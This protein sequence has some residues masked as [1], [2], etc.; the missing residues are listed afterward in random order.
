MKSSFVIIF[1]LSNILV[2]Y[3]IVDIN[4]VCTVIQAQLN[5]RKFSYLQIVCTQSYL[6]LNSILE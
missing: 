4:Q 5:V 1:A 2:T 3:I 6:K